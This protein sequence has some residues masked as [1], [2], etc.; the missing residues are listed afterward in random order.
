MTTSCV[1]GNDLWG[2]WSLFILAQVKTFHRNPWGD[3]PFRSDSVTRALRSRPGSCRAHP[4][5]VTQELTSARWR[6]RAFPGRCADHGGGEQNLKPRSPRPSLLL[7]RL[8]SWPLQGGLRVQ[9]HGHRSARAGTQHVSAYW[10]W[11]LP[12]LPG[13]ASARGSAP[14]CGL[15][16]GSGWGCGRSPALPCVLA[17]PQVLPGQASFPPQ[18]LCQ[19]CR[20]PGRVLST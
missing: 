7:R 5:P 9:G 16:G 17:T 13:R 6:G 11:P 20:G 8:L 18:S 1:H 15:P 3:C 12:L 4:A 2:F 10:C 19:L 14:R